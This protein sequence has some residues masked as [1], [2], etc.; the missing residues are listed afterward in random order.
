M[1]TLEKTINLL[2]TLPDSKIEVVYEFVRSIDSRTHEMPS[3]PTPTN[4]ENVQSILGIAHEYAN[5]A[6]IDQEE[7]TFERVIAEK[8]ASFRY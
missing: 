5:P 7:G 3:E 4:I 1:S 2:E 6:L 8:Y